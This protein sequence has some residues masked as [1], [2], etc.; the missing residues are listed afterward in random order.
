MEDIA[1][2]C[3]ESTITNEEKGNYLEQY[4]IQTW[5]WA[6]IFH[7]QTTSQT[8]LLRKFTI[9]GELCKKPKCHGTD[10]KGKKTECQS[11][12]ITV[13]CTCTGTVAT[14]LKANK[15]EKSLL[16]SSHWWNLISNHMLNL[17]I[18]Q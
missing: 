2:A 5:P 1:V 18:L 17:H 10:Q 4:I 6:I 9:A 3:T 12:K 16:I 7:L 8:S 15:K 13:E 11:A 14:S